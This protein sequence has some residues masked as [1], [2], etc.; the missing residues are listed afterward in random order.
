VD[1]SNL[2]LVLRRPAPYASAGTVLCCIERT[3]SSLG[4][5]PMY[6]LGTDGSAWDTELASLAGQQ[7]KS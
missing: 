7:R 4:K 3:K 5:A 6:V 1:L 2:A